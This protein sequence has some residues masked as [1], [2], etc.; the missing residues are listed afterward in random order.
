MSIEL[1]F[2]KTKCVIEN[3]CD[4]QVF[5]LEK[6]VLIYTPLISIVHLLIIMA[7]YDVKD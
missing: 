3:A 5:L 1:F 4:D 2:D 7:N 6:D